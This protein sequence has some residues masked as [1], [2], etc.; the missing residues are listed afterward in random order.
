[1]K[2]DLGIMRSFSEAMD[3]PENSFNSIHIAGTNGKGSTASVLYNI[4][5]QSRKTGLYTS[6]HLI[7]FNERIIVDR[8]P[9]SDEMIAEF[10]SRN[11]ESIIELS[12]SN[13]NPT[14]FE[15]TTMMAFDH[16]RSTKAEYAAV[17][18]GLGGRLDSTNIIT[19]EVSVIAQIGYEHADKLGCSLTS[20]AT[21][22]GGIIKPG[23]PVILLDEKPE[24]VST[25]KRLSSVR[26]S[27]LIRVTSETNVSDITMT[28]KGLTFK[29]DTPLDSYFIE[30]GLLG[31]FQIGNISTA[32]LAAENTSSGVTKKDI[33]K[34]VREARWPGRMEVISQ[35]PKIILDSAHNPP[36][37]SFLV[38]SFR[39]LFGEKPK[40]VV[41]MLSDKDAY[42]YLSVIS[43]LSDDIIF[44]SPREEK[45]AWDPFRIDHLYGDMFRN[46]RVIEDPVEAYKYASEN[47]DLALI[48]GSMYLV[49]YI[50]EYRD[51]AVMPYMIN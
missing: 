13:R 31:S 26:D 48:T 10:I 38:N 2:L 44:T 50:K 51:G 45:R 19:P 47:S 8:E 42:S 30:T 28:E 46:H 34:G 20:I 49:G 43:K 1:M 3:H 9:I 14:F 41:G 21:E 35:N 29:L 32:V 24:V 7:R 22:K 12:K 16:F 15:T 36:A 4:L 25:V 39:K 5:R 40:L 37:A 17:E 33:E 18:V 6:P 23:I 11:K 27:P